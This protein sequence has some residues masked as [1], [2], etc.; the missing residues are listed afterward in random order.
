M[1]LAAGAWRR[2]VTLAIVGGCL[3]SVPG[4][5]RFLNPIREPLPMIQEAFLE[6]PPSSKKHVYIFF[7][8]GLD[9]LDSANFFGVNNYVRQLGFEKV[10][11]G[12]L[13][14]AAYFRKEIFR[15]HEEDSMAHFVLIGFSFGANVV[16]SLTNGMKER[17]IPVDLLVYL[18]GNT[19]KDVPED[20][21]SNALRIV[22]IL[23]SGC[24]WNGAWLEGAENIHETDVWHFGTPSHPRTLAVLARQLADV[25][26][27]FAVEDEQA[28]A[29]EKSS[30]L[31]EA[32]K[33]AKRDEWDFL[34]PVA[35]LP[36]PNE[37]AETKAKRDQAE[38]QHVMRDP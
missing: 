10:Y 2:A 25:A 35:Q 7:V 5:L 16:R 32:L 36:I 13:Y 29:A 8:H 24:I 3:I 14:H 17:D 11:Y 27:S 12:H 21:P 20:R 33:T 6:A 34:M 38:K 31:H 1:R 4:C 30:P 23:A 19:L 15:I 22:N 9:P 28:V 37:G 26:A 18:G